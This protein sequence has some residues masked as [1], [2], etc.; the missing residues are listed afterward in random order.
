[1]LLLVTNITIVL[2]F[3]AK[4]YINR[5]IIFHQYSANQSNIRNLTRTS[6]TLSFFS[7]ETKENTREQTPPSTNEIQYHFCLWL[8][9]SAETHGPV[10][11]ARLIHHRMRRAM[12]TSLEIATYGARES[13]S[14]ARQ[15][16]AAC[17]FDYP[18][19]FSTD[20][21]SSS[22]RKHFGSKKRASDSSAFHQRSGVWHAATTARNSRA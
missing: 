8:I 12:I 11:K 14:R 21:E 4:Y 6:S 5:T 2:L 13:E 20:S 1:M 19:I 17:R 15:T 3:K 22:L 18:R 16:N 9:H 10:S 7:V